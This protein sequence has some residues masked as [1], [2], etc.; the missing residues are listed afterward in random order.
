MEDR[1]SRILLEPIYLGWRHEGALGTRGAPRSHIRLPEAAPLR[2]RLSEASRLVVVMAD[3]REPREIERRTG[4]PAPLDVGVELATSD[5]V[6]GAGPAEPDPST[7]AGA[8]RAV[9]E[10]GLSGSAVLFG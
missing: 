2:G 3:A 6:V 7:A 1:A 8:D 5:S 4:G 10:V 9:H